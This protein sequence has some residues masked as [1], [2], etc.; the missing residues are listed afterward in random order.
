[1]HSKSWCLFMLLISHPSNQESFRGIA[2]VRILNKIF[3]T[4]HCVIHVVHVNVHSDFNNTAFFPL[5]FL[6]S[7]FLLRL[8]H[9]L[10]FTFSLPIWFFSE[11]IIWETK[12]SCTF[13]TDVSGSASD[14]VDQSSHWSQAELSE[15]QHRHNDWLPS[16]QWPISLIL[17]IILQLQVALRLQAKGDFSHEYRI[18]E[19]L[20]ECNSFA[21][22]EIHVHKYV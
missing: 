1:M 21:L 13:C 17:E 20:W 15:M 6:F 19:S 4:V 7:F 9:S 2:H 5:H 14:A 22:T 12:I 8:C 16:N 10:A 11:E 18:K 3:I